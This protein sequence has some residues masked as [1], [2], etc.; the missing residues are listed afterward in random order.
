MSG[1][2]SPLSAVRMA[3]TRAD[4]AVTDIAVQNKATLHGGGSSDIAV[5]LQEL[6]RRLTDLS[7]ANEQLLS[8]GRP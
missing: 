8:A 6:Q 7:S 4:A 1:K 2:H 3:D 5:A